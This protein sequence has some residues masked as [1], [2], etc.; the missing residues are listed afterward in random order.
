MDFYRNFSA[1]PE[2]RMASYLQAMRCPNYVSIETIKY[3]LNHEEV[4]Q[5][6][7][8]VWSHLS[9]IAKS[10]S[11]VRVA[12]QG[13]LIDS[14]LGT[15]YRLDIRKFSRNF[16]H[17]LFFDEYNFG[18]NS[19]A[20]LIFG[21][22][23]YMPR[24]FT[25]NFTADLFGES[26]NLFE[27][28]A[29]MQGFEH[30]IE[31]FFG[32]AGPMNA[33]KVR[34]KFGLLTKYFK[35]GY[36]E[37]DDFDKMSMRF[38]RTPTDDGLAQNRSISRRSSRG[39]ND[40]MNNDIKKLGYGLKYD[41]KDPKAAFGFK[42]FGNDLKYKTIEGLPEIGNMIQQFNLIKRMNQ[43]LSGKEITYT[44]SGVFLDASYDVPLSSGLPLSIHAFGASSV[45]MRMSGSLNNL[46]FDKKIQLAV[47][48]KFKPR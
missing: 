11:P 37:E 4:N 41:F 28:S 45:D 43:V 21:T 40:L 47:E 25:F 23:S 2:I 13:L 17:S 39:S 15:K 7:S 29:R 10:S 20:N 42:M 32:P 38:K 30:L 19:D 36:P 44:K 26:V 48:G 12:A 24:A 34:E 3:V 16:E 5:V 33:N 18:L 6:G 46:N 1:N 35:Y 31:S 8:F 9:N 22:D 27:I 14:D